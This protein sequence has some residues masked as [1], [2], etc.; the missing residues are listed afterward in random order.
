M[1]KIMMTFAAVLCCWMTLYAQSLT[2]QQAMERV[3][4]Y[5]NSGKA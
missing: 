2:E 5:M 3:L 1:K 4:Q